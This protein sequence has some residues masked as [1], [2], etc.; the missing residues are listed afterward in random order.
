MTMAH[1]LTIAL[2]ASLAGSACGP[3]KNPLPSDSTGG[4]SVGMGSADETASGP[5]PELPQGAGS[6][7]PMDSARADREFPEFGGKTR[8]VS[9]AGDESCRTPSP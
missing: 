7:N 5:E 4:T 3:D 8:R 6:A 9:A 2:L 1:R